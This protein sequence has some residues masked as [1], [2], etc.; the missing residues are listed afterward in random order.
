[1]LFEEEKN[2]KNIKI[3]ENNRNN[4]SKFSSHFYFKNKSFRNNFKDDLMHLNDLEK[5]Y[6]LLSSIGIKL[7]FT[8]KVNEI[9][10][11][12]KAPENSPYRNGIFNF[13]I[14]FDM[15]YPENKPQLKIKTKIFH[16][17]VSN[18]GHCIRFLNIWDEKNSKISLILIGLYEFF[19]VMLM[20]LVMKMKL[21]KYIKRK[22]LFYLSK[23]A[24]NALRI[25]RLISLIMN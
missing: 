10:G 24:K 21:I 23:N 12:I 11:F 15:D 6:G 18:D 13:L 17:E 3:F 16:A 14:K 25:I 19:L 4:I 2:I 9:E 22:I 1:M 5:D 20:I 7:L 8:E